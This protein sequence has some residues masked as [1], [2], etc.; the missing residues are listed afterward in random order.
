[1]GNYRKDNYESKRSS[2]NNRVDDSNVKN[3][4]PKLQFAGVGM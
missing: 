1:M 4:G 3:A 2:S